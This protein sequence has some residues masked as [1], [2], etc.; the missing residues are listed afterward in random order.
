[1]YE[2]IFFAF[3]NFC[4]IWIEEKYWGIFNFLGT[5]AIKS[6]IIF[7]LCNGHIEAKYIEAKSQLWCQYT[8]QKKILSHSC[9]ISLKKLIKHWFYDTILQ[10]STQ[11]IDETIITSSEMTSK[12]GRK[13]L[14]RFD[15]RAERPDTPSTWA[16]CFWSPAEKDVTRNK[17]MKVVRRSL[18]VFSALFPFLFVCFKHYSVFLVYSCRRTLCFLFE[19]SYV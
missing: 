18:L 13:V 7:F 10:N 19:F 8:T 1:M 15:S 12:F 11:L 4:V 17:R 14:G 5:S 3:L 2:G 6:E 9:C 16:T